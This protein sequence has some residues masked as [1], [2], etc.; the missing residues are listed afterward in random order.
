MSFFLTKPTRKYWEVGG[1]F[2]GGT[3]PRPWVLEGDAQ[4]NP[5]THKAVSSFTAGLHHCCWQSSLIPLCL[6][7]FRY[8]WISKNRAYLIGLMQD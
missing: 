2:Q 1:S 4:P 8:K 5:H 7:F 3:I 6:S